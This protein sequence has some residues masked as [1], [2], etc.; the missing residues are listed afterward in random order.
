MGIGFR[1]ESRVTTVHRVVSTRDD[2]L[3][4]KELF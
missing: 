1:K 4:V 3:L 2:R